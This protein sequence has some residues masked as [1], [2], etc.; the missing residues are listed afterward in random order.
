[1]LTRWLTNHNRDP[2]TSLG[3]ETPP[4][5]PL[6][7]GLNLCNTVL[8]YRLILHRAPDP[9]EP[10]G[11]HVPSLPRL[12]S[13]RYSRFSRP[14]LRQAPWAL[15]GGSSEGHF[16]V[17]EGNFGGSEGNGLD[18]RARRECCL[19]AFDAGK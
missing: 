7:K 8:D 13:R 18:N 15:R 5:G 12:F 16:R 10:R 11:C 1:M 17:S 19:E 2:K 9:G 14:S 4:G 6:V 3:L